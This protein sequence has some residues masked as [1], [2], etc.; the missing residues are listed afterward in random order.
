MLFI[1]Y[2][3]LTFLSASLYSFQSH[4]VL[5]QTVA[6]T[7]PSDCRPLSPPKA[8]LTE[9]GKPQI[10]DLTGCAELTRVKPIQ[11]VVNP[12]AWYFFD[13]IYQEGEKDQ[14]DYEKLIRILGKD[15]LFFAAVSGDL[16]KISAFYHEN[17]KAR[18]V[19]GH[20]R[21]TM[22]HL[23]ILFRQRELATYLVENVK[24]NINAVTEAGNTPLD[25]INPADV[26]M[27]FLLF[28]H[29][30]HTGKENALISQFVSK[31]KVNYCLTA[32]WVKSYG[33]NGLDPVP[34]NI[35]DI[36][37]NL[38]VNADIQGTAPIMLPKRNNRCC[39]I[40]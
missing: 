33:E 4:A 38:S 20:N 25:F 13:P 23:A 5:R 8:E 22:L 9:L 39:I 12:R 24:L 14:P 29:G 6:S 35:S 37:G 3:F 10:L 17:P 36:D 11:G 27:Y 19:V 28:M 2:Y 26:E 34:E 1:L 32:A 40:Q 18:V 16:T 30:A 7:C 15:S 31:A 21:W